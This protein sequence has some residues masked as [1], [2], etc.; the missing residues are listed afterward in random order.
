MKMAN[1]SASVVPTME[2]SS[3]GG[4]AG[5]FS[6]TLVGAFSLRAFFAASAAKGRKNGL[7]A[8]VGFALF[9]LVSVRCE[10]GLV[11][12]GQNFTREGA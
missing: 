1:V 11:P 9:F 3:G 10:R 7:S 5:G 8:D 2:A 6:G 4:L 12:M